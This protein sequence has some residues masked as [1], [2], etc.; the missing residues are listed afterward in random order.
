M[1]RLASIAVALFVFGG[2][3]FGVSSSAGADG[4]NQN[5]CSFVPDSGIFFDFH[6][7][8]DTHDLCYFERTYGSTDAGREQ[9]DLEFY[10]DMVDSCDDKWPVWHQFG[11]RAICNGVAYTYYLGVRLFG[12][13]GWTSGGDPAIG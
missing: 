5:G 2:V 8:C 9:C 3:L 12:G 10:W 7:S 6:E 4:P 11:S 13:F 1:K